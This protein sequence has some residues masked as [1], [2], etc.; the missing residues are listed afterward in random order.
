MNEGLP[1]NSYINGFHPITILIFFLGIIGTGMF[2]NDIYYVGPSFF[3]A[4]LNTCAL[5]G[6][7][8]IKSIIKLS[9]IVVL[10]TTA[11][12]GLFVHNGTTILF[13]MGLNAVTLEAFIYG[14]ISGLNIAGMLVWFI[15][16]NQIMTA[17]KIS[18]L[19][20]RIA[21]SISLLISMIF[22]FIP[23]IRTR[24]I[25]IK[26]VSEITYDLSSTNG[27]K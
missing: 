23:L 27:I 18:Y 10:F 21:P 16:F 5:K 12:N 3:L 6:I 15:C 26:N 8:S 1:K 11:L 20:G 4:I 9:L 7:K 2:I 24:F 19:L 14:M 22:R 17:D 13:Y 25:E